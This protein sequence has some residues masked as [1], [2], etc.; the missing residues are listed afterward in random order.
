MRSIRDYYAD[1]DIWLLFELDDDGRPSRQ[2]S[3]RGADGEP[4]IAAALVE[5]MHARDHGGIGAVQAYESKYGVLAEG[6]ADD[7]DLEGDSREEMTAGEFEKAWT[8]AR[9]TIEDRGVRW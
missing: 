8:A 5:V 9:S 6:S 2:I 3:L 7:W 1:E 4:V